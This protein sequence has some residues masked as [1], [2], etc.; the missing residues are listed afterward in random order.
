LPKI[1]PNVKQKLDEAYE[2]L[3][4]YTRNA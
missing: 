2:N 3:G 1:P 4:Q